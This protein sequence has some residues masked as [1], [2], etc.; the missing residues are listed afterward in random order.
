MSHANRGHPIPLRLGLGILGAIFLA[1]RG[2][3]AATPSPQATRNFLTMERSL[4]QDFERYFGEDLATV[5]QTPQ[6]V[7]GILAERAT[8]TQS[9]AAVLWVIPRLD[10]LHLVLLTPDGDPV[11]RDLDHVPQSLLLTTVRTFQKEMADLSQDPRRSQAAQQLYDWIIAPFQDDY[12]EPNQIDSLLFCL[13]NGLRGLPLAALRNESSYLIEQYSVTSIPA[14]NLIQTQYR[15]IRRGEILAAGASQFQSLAPLPAVPTELERV[16]S[17]LRNSPISSQIWQGRSLLNQRFTLSNVETELQ[18]HPLN[19]VHLATHA[20]FKPGRPQQSFIQFHDR[21]LR[22]D[23]MDDLVWP[24]TLD[25][26]V[27]SACKTALG[28]PGAELGFAGVALKSRI[29]SAMGSLWQV[30]DVGT[31]A[32]MD[33]FY[34]YLPRT[35]TKAHALQQAQLQ[36]LKGKV[37]ANESPLLPAASQG[38]SG[39]GPEITAGSPDS[40]APQTHE[41]SH[42]YFWAGFTLLSSP[43]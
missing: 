21:R 5:T 20:E 32:L 31:L 35:P 28:D 12:L 8:Q 1:Q 27:L 7:A 43:W 29:K 16:Q 33:E 39:L 40:P 4:E 2:P 25:L 24:P 15:P 34:H 14:F 11:V 36:L 38:R 30:S 37:Y 26:L 41:F 18:Q 23:Q 17:Q 19:I 10:H 3:A 13:G 6:A 9:R 22:L 42:P